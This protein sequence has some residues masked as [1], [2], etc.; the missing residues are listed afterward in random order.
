M[1]QVVIETRKDEQAYECTEGDTILRSALRN[2][3]GFP[4]ACNVGSCGNCKFTLLEGEVRHLREDPPALSKRD[5][6]R[7][8]YLGCQAVPQ[9]DCRIKMRPNDEYE[10]VNPPATTGAT[11]RARKPLTHDI[12]EFEF[13]LH[14]PHVFIPG[15][16]ALL[17]LPGVKGGRAYSMCNLPGDGTTWSF[18][19]KKVPNGEATSRLFD[20]LEVGS[21]ITLDGPYGTAH[22]QEDSP[23]DILCIAG[24]SGLSPMI[25]IARA[26]AAH[27]ELK[28]RRLDFIFG[29]RT[30]KD[31][32]GED[33]LRELEG[34]GDTLHFHAAISNPQDDDGSWTGETGFVHE[35]AEKLFADEL[36]DREIYFAGP[37]AM[38]ESMQQMLF[39]MEADLEHV[40]Y[41]EFF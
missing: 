27:P 9:G 22:I 40:H 35:L 21:Q 11:L 36:K 4:Y 37:P 5:A 30:G 8:R 6:E 10:P 7:G 13:E 25:S 20:D 3:I 33:I 16:Y 17:H 24:G 31:I 19:V 26:V 28:H 2:G 1:T 23:R 39:M 41:D 14:Q 18:Q 34:F 38:A 29:G 32:C 15:Q 12:E